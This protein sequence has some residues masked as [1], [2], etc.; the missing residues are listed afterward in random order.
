MWDQKKVK[1]WVRKSNKWLRV[2]VLLCLRWSR[3]EAQNLFWQIWSLYT[4]KEIESSSHRFFG[5]CFLI[6]Y[7]KSGGILK[8]SS[9]ALKMTPNNY[10][11]FPSSRFWT[12]FVTFTS[13]CVRQLFP[14]FLSIWCAGAERDLAF[15]YFYS[16][17]E[18]RLLNLPFIALFQKVPNLRSYCKIC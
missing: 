4:T 5:T 17:L 15:P 9:L 12:S 16:K 13:L 1:G 2:K 3:C 10:K 18:I 14:D 7:W 6:N 11:A 8:L